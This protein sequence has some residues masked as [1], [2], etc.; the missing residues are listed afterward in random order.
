MVVAASKRI[1]LGL[2]L[3]T[4]VWPKNKVSPPP[5][6]D[7]S[8]DVLFPVPFSLPT[9]RKACNRLF[10]NQIKSRTNVVIILSVTSSLYNIF[11]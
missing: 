8:L 5:P 2:N 6:L 3:R 9:I 7:P 1:F 11:S 10:M 4:S